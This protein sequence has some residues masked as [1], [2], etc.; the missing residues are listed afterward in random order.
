MFLIYSSLLA[1]P[2]ASSSSSDH[3]PT[4]SVD[5]VQSP[6]SGNIG[7]SSSEPD[8][9]LPSVEPQP[10]VA[11][12]I[13][14]QRYRSFWESLLPDEYV[15]SI[16]RHG[17]KI[18]FRDG[19]VPGQYREPNNRSALDNMPYLQ[20]HVESLIL[21]RIV[22]ECF[23]PP[24]CISP[25]TVS[26]RYVL[27]ELKLR[28]CIDLSRYINL[29]LKKEA[30]T[31]PGLEKAL[32]SLLPNDFQATFDLKSA[33]HHVKIHPEHRKYRVTAVSANIFLAFTKMTVA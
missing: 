4:P 20:D 12:N 26:S 10:N 29:L 3:I 22:L 7:L 33:F 6:S 2:S 30:V 19:V 9:S 16:I 15:L 8:T 27:R 23:S 1:D 28:M 31:L 18:P 17:Y 21:D 14:N 11:G 5:S 25:L 24:L 13:H 32:K